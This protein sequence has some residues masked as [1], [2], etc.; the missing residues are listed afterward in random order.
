[1]TNTLVK[2]EEITEKPSFKHIVNWGDG[3]YM[4]GKDGW[5]RTYGLTG[6]LAAVIY[7]ENGNEEERHAILTHYSLGNHKI[8]KEKIEELAE[9]YPEMNDCEKKRA[10]LF[11]LDGRE[12]DT[13]VTSV[14]DVIIKEFP[15]IKV[16][17]IEYLKGIKEDVANTL[18]VRLSSKGYY[19][20]L[21]GIDNP[22][23]QLDFD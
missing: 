7:C 1:M 17:R 23:G 13:C 6:C 4:C 12:K 18:Y 2:E 19:A 20:D 22:H 8:H 9:E 5:L 3:G 14:E 10:L 21:L 16:K 15:D 11:V